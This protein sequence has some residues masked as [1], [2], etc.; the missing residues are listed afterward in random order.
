MST[1]ISWITSFYKIITHTHTHFIHTRETHHLLDTLY[2][3]YQNCPDIAPGWLT[4]SRGQILWPHLRVIT[5]FL[6]LETHTFILIQFFYNYVLFSIFIHYFS[7]FLSFLSNYTIF[8]HLFI[9][10]TNTILHHHI[11]SLTWLLPYTNYRHTTKWHMTIRLWRI[12]FTV[13]W[14]DS[15]KSDAWRLRSGPTSGSLLKWTLGRPLI[16]SEPALGSQ[17]RLWLRSS[18]GGRTPVREAGFRRRRRHADDAGFR[19]TASKRGNGGDV[20]MTSVIEHSCPGLYNRGPHTDH[21]M[22]VSLQMSGESH[23]GIRRKMST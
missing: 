10:S 18:C 19:P 15:D 13:P 11:Y 7:F 2:N 12:G 4:L 3:Y 20:T 17:A 23:S 21:A 22:V 16:R 5:F 14:P 6:V 1:K 9:L 8:P